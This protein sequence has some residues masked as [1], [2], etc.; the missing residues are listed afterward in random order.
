[1]IGE[2]CITVSMGL[3]YKIAHD[4]CFRLASMPSAQHCPDLYKVDYRPK[5][6]KRRHVLSRYEHGDYVVVRKYLIT[7]KPE[8]KDKNYLP[9][10][11]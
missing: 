6:G 2:Y 11:I 9:E 5:A 4:K 10:Q 8:Y 1:M 3:T 7:D